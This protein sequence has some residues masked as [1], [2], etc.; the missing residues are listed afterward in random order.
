MSASPSSSINRRSSGASLSNLPTP[1]TPTTPA[2]AKAFLGFLL[3]GKSS[4]VQEKVAMFSNAPTKSPPKSP[5]VYSA[6]RLIRSESAAVEAKPDN[7]NTQGPLNTER[8]A[9]KVEK[10]ALKIKLS[11]GSADEESVS[12]FEEPKLARTEDTMPFV[13]A[14]RGQTSSAVTADTHEDFD[15]IS[16]KPTKVITSADIPMDIKP[17]QNPDTQTEAHDFASES[18]MLVDGSTPESNIVFKEVESVSE[19]DAPNRSPSPPPQPSSVSPS[20]M[21]ITC[22]EEDQAINPPITAADTTPSPNENQRL[23]RSDD[24]I[25]D[26][27]SESKC[28]MSGSASLSRLRLLSGLMLLRCSA[29]VVFYLWLSAFLVIGCCLISFY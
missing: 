28:A 8:E 9:H 6:K 4:P 21:P 24:N 22:R 27:E 2:E 18:S 29:A 5:P 7:N 26:E 13:S 15:N 16:A 10:A 17:T 23:Q 3:G 14:A 1:T 11:S 12:E 25:T 20:C 19:S